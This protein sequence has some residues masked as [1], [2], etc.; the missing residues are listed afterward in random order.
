MRRAGEIGNHP[1]IKIPLPNKTESSESKR[2]LEHFQSLMGSR[3]QT[4]EEHGDPFPSCYNEIMLL[5]VLH[6]LPNALQMEGGLS[7]TAELI[8]GRKTTGQGGGV[9]ALRPGRGHH[10]RLFGFLIVRSQ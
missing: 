7:V 5:N 4:E 10:H 8:R 1:K 3:W 9:E 2:G 6:K